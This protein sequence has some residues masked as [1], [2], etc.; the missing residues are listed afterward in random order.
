M[1]VSILGNGLTSLTL[2]KL[3]VHYWD[4]KSGNI[5]IGGTNIN[6]VPVEKLMDHIS[7][8]D[9]DTFLFNISIMEN[10]R[11]GNPEASNEE[12][13][14]ASKAAMCHDFIMAMDKGYDTRPGDY[15]D[16]LSGGEKQRITIARAVLK[17][18][19]IV[20]LDEAT[21]FADSENEDKIQRAISRLT[22]GKIVIVVA[23]RL[24]TIVDANK[25]I[26]MKE[27]RVVGQGSH[28]E[29]LE[30]NEEYK[31]LWKAHQQSTNWH[32]NIKEEN[33]A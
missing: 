14:M 10:I 31:K 27:G 23:H 2:A 22:S 18:A 6:H 28:E 19:P 16:K 11:L 24:S 1:K 17:N 4:V 8:V 30:S 15:G 33:Y 7:Y 26:V 12:V 9:Q 20:V 5:T 32:L 29:L 25:I 13:M 3:L 21:A